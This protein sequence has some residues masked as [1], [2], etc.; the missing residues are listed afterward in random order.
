MNIIK[1]QPVQLQFLQSKADIVF[2]GGGGGGGKVGP[3]DSKIQTP[4]GS[5]TYGEVSVGDIILNPDGSR[6]KV[7][8]KYPHKDWDFYRVTFT[9]GSSTE[10][11]MEHLWVS[12][13]EDQEFLAG[14]LYPSSAKVRTTGEL[15]DILFEGTRLFIPVSKYI[16]CE[17]SYNVAIDVVTRIIEDHGRVSECLECFEIDRSHIGDLDFFK[18]KVYLLGGLVYDDHISDKIKLKFPKG[19]FSNFCKQGRIYTSTEMSLCRELQSIEF[20]RV[21]DGACISVDNPNRLYLTDDFIVTHNTWSILIDN[22]QG[23]HDPLYF[24]V[25]FRS[26]LTEISLGLW[27]EALRLYSPYLKDANGKFIGKAHISRKEYIITFPSGARC[28]F[29]YMERD[30]HADS[31]YGTEITKAYFDEF[32]FRS[33]YQFST[34][35]SRNRSM[36]QTPKGIRAT[37][38]PDRHHFVYEW[39]KFY[40]DDEGFPR[41]ELSGILRYYY[42]IDGEL[43]TSWDMQELRDKYGVPDKNGYIDPPESYTYIPSTLEDNEELTKRDPKYRAKLNS[44]PERAKKQLLLGCWADEDDFGKYFKRSWVKE[45]P[46]QELPKDCVW[47]RGYDLGYSA[48]TSDAPKPDYTASVI[49]GK[50]KESNVHV[51]GDYHC[52]FKDPDTEIHGQFRKT[53]GDRDRVMLKQAEYDGKSVYISLPKENAGGKEIYQH[54]VKMFTSAGFIVKLDPMSANA[55]KMKKF[56]AF[57]SCCESGIVYIYPDSFPNKVTYENYLS[58]LER[59]NPDKKSTSGY[60]DDIADCTGTA[61]NTVMQM[62]NISIVARNQQPTTTIS[63]N[64]LQKR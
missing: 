8:A 1:P 17:A 54:K 59:F 41:K 42:R 5:T 9:D 24:S 39:I 22:L 46:L 26:T 16:K 25:F 37:L 23:V 12:W 50:D 6:Q 14:E 63:T 60:K 34:I 10:V 55:N 58:S 40:L 2:F 64:I 11:G 33:Q 4:W 21:S 49:V 56:E 57:S 20:S 53:P 38:N 51:R 27:P 62:R 31:W 19:M 44:L 29:A 7:I 45:K 15:Y 43:I 28:K 35:L 48:P 36:S 32:Q 18:S 3:N 30:E 13:G 52:E 61:F 47:V